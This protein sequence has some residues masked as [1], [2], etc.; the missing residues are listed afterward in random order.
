MTATASELR[1]S[2]MA[3]A[4]NH[5]DHVDDDWSIRAYAVLKHFVACRKSPFMCEEV[6]KYALNEIGLPKPP[7]ERAWGYLMIKAAKEGLI[8]HNGYDKTKSASAHRTPAAV[9]VAA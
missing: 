5:A 1:N 2:G 3:S 9:W 7:S 4:I 8:K 6:R